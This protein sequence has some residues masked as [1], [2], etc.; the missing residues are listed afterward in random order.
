M[1]ITVVSWNT[2]KKIY[3]EH[4][5]NL[6]AELL[7][8]QDFV[9]EA[10]FYSFLGAQVPNSASVLLDHGQVLSTTLDIQF[11]KK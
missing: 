4:F 8:I 7:R 5:S 10:V 3:H 6:D 11:R 9:D 1:I 2:M